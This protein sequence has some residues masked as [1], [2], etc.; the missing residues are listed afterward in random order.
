MKITMLSVSKSWA[1]LRTFTDSKTE[2]HGFLYSCEGNRKG[3]K[4]FQRGNKNQDFYREP[5]SC[6]TTLLVKS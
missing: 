5:E 3:I 1:T 6:R 2:S 4:P